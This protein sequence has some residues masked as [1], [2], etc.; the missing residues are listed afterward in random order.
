MG[1]G[2]GLYLRVTTTGSRNWIQ[3]IQFRGR[4][5]DIGL[6]AF[7]LVPL[8]EARERANENRRLSRSGGDPLTAKRKA[9]MPTFREATERT[10]EA[11]RPHW[12]SERGAAEWLQS[13]VSH[14]YPTLADRP[15][16]EIDRADVLRA[17]SPLS[18][19]KPDRARRL[20]R[21]IK[22]V[23]AWAQ[24]FGFI[25]V[26]PAG[27]VID[28]AVPRAPKVKHFRALPF[29]E[30]GKALETIEACRA[31]MAARACLRFLVLTAGRSGEVRGATWDEIDLE[32]RTWTIPASRMK[33]G[34]EHRVP[35]SGEALDVLERVRMLR[36]ESGL[37]FPAPTRRGRP[38]ADAT[39]GLALRHAGLA[40][41][42]TVHGFRS[43]FRDWCAETGKPR[44]LAEAALA[45]TVG[46][47]EG[48]YFRSD[49]FEKR[50]AL[51]EA[52]GQFVAGTKRAKIYKL[53][54]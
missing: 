14:A 48:A 1:D 37:I 10:F 15:V 32:R 29:A 50:R 24:S 26:N 8:A 52:W 6:G 17:L 41:R 5:H 46:R 7:P 33:A 49:L 44:E 43:S 47:V 2:G 51:M 22:S 23:L 35:L 36:D 38:L 20:R 12:K 42:A 53:R 27:E 4:R 28:A 21:R 54:G 9:A 31:S 3:R 30:V 19:T 39:L 34:R 45:H 16:D 18:E 25:D 40:D 13:L 11:N